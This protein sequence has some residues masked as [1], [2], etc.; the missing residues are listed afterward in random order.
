MSMKK[1]GDVVHTE[2]YTMNGEEKKKYTNL[3]ALFQR[4]DGSYTIAFLGGWLNVFE[5]RDKPQSTHN[6][7]KANGYQKQLPMEDDFSDEIPF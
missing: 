5:P 2:K 3:G 7:A 1:L 4:E 6:Q